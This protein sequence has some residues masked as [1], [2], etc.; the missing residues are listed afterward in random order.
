M[1]HRKVI[2]RHTYASVCIHANMDRHA[3]VSGALALACGVLMHF[4]HL[5][6]LVSLNDRIGW[7]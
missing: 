2:S 3:Y 5:E 6:V 7:G 4:L 1:W